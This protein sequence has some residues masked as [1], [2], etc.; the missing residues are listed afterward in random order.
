MSG[1][2]VKAALWYALLV[3]FLL[4]GCTTITHTG[5]E[6]YGLKSEVRQV[7]VKMFQAEYDPSSGTEFAHFQEAEEVLFTDYGR[8]KE[9]RLLDDQMN[10]YAKFVKEYNRRGANTSIKKL[11]TEG[12]VI[13]NIVYTE[14]D[15]D[16]RTPLKATAYDSD[17]RVSHTSEF[18]DQGDGVM[19]HLNYLEDQVERITYHRDEN[20]HLIRSEL[21]VQMVGENGE[22]QLLLIDEYTYT[23]FDARGNWTRAVNSHR[24]DYDMKRYKLERTIVYY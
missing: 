9:M 8:E 2:S 17:G 10:L 20:G 22:W 24:T 13:S 1:L 11:D 18:Q 4:S 5:W 21:H 23:E 6:D 16:G 3:L 15:E 19:I 12:E 14:F 7:T